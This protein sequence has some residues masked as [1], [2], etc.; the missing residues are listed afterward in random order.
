MRTQQKSHV[1]FEKL[2]VL[3]VTI[4]WIMGTVELVAGEI[5]YVA[6]ASEGGGNGQ[7][8]EQA[9]NDLQLAIT[10]SHAT[11]TIWVAQGVY[12]P[13]DD[14]E[15]HFTLVD[16]VVLLGGFSGDETL[17]TQ[18]DP[19]QNMT[20]LSG[21]IGDSLQSADNSYHV[22][23]VASGATLSSMTVLDGFHIS[24]GN[25]TGDF[26]SGWGGGL[27]L[28]S[29]SPVISNCVF[30]NNVAIDG[31]A[32]HVGGNSSTFI[33]VKISNNYAEQGG[34]A[35]NL[36][37]STG[38]RFINCS[39][40]NNTSQRYGGAVALDLAGAKFEG[41]EFIN[42]TAIEDKGGA[43]SNYTFSHPVLI[44]C[45][46]YGN[47]ALQGGSIW[48]G[49]AYVTLINSI[50]WDNEPDEIYGGFEV[51]VSHSDV[52]G[53]LAGEGNISLDPG[54]LDPTMG[55]LQLVSTSP[56]IDAGVTLLVHEGDT[57]IHLEP[58][59]YSGLAPD[60]GAN[61][62]PYTTVGLDEKGPIASK[63]T[64]H[65]NHPNP[66]N[67]STTIRYELP[68]QSTVRLTVYDI[69]GKEVHV[70]ENEI[71]GEGTHQVLWNGCDRDGNP[72]N[73]GIYFARIQAG[74]FSESI[75]MVYLR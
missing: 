55:D 53:G 60:M 59:E 39:F 23:Y 16:S 72:M 38:T 26:D 58:D 5:V 49:G 4:L 75:K 73:T 33:N 74:E 12:R 8:W 24:E 41:C 27:F 15:D 36:F 69:L 21:N 29:G 48:S 32:I 18:R 64:L 11:D 67:P 61:E 9:Y 52:Q 25:A 37:G 70:L 3:L 31:G 20:T 35:I 63:F 45:S 57:L 68:A 34:G 46:F 28:G 71:R 44:N 6:A 62:S 51:L 47:S 40:F 2:I 19:E 50:L 17:H 66:F 43:I 1:N 14:R 56:C 30:Q 22:I 65:P 13:G 54:F 42:N 7:S 10:T